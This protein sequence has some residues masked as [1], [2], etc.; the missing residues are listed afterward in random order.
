[1]NKK[2]KEALRAVLPPA[3]F[4][5]MRWVT[6]KIDV[7]RLS[8]VDGYMDP[9]LCDLVINKTKNFKSEITDKKQIDMNVTRL[10]LPF[11]FM[12]KTKTLKI[13]DFGGGAGIQYQ[14][15]KFLFPNQEFH[16]VIVENMNFSQSS[17][18]Q[19]SPELEFRSTITEA[20]STNS[21]F[22][23]VVASS[24]LQYT[25]DPILYLQELCAI[26]A[27]YLY[28]TRQILNHD[29]EF[30]SFNQVTKLRDHGPG[31]APVK[32]NNKKTM[33]KLIAVPVATFEE[34]LEKNYI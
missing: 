25:E 29:K 33:N 26:R 27:P 14:V 12:P 31:Q 6:Y 24:S 30:L 11:A 18:V 34:T 13:L 32:F 7:S 1:M 15:A 3:V 9:A 10:T 17:I 28:I 23:L 22:D 20:V 4:K 5:W 16:W 21:H 8:G 2:V 19:S